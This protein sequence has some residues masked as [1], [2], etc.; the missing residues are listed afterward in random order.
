MKKEG[1]FEV[2][3]KLLKSTGGGIQVLLS[4]LS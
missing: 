4:Q 2:H 1:D 3:S